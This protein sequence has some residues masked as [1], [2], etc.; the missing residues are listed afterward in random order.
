[1]NQEEQVTTTTTTTTEVVL[2]VE[3]SPKKQLPESA[4][5]EVASPAKAPEKEEE[6]EDLNTTVRVAKDSS[7]R[8]LITFVMARL[9]RGGEVTI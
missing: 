7:V 5:A 9:E 3:P 8:K 2:P 1:M 4:A 6:P